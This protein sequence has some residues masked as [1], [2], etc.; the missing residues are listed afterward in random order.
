MSAATRSGASLS[1]HHRVFEAALPSMDDAIRYQ[2]RKWPRRLRADALADARAACWHA[3]YGLIRRGQDPLAIGPT[4]IATNA[5]RYV[6]NG[7]RLG[8]GPSGRGVMDFFNP[9]AQKASGLKLI[10]IDRSAERDATAQP[11]LWREW[12]AEDNRT[13]PANEAAFRLDLAVWLDG[14]PARKR[15]MAELLAQGCGTGEV[16]ALLDVTAPAVSIARTWL[17]ASWRE[18]QN[19]PVQEDVPS[20]RR[21]VGRPRKEDRDARR[22]RQRART[23]VRE[24]VETS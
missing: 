18:F 9:K 14:L 13:T 7:R 10:S 17:E 23:V 20:E 11:D 24:L 21:P 19:E 3:W 2:F 6:K 1:A 5:A 22:G 12:L 4:G 8:T 16:A 15:Q